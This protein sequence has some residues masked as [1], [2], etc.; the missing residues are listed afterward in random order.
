MPAYQGR[1][2][3]R[4][5]HICGGRI[6]DVPRDPGEAFITAAGSSAAALHGGRG[7]D[8]VPGSC[9][10]PE[11]V[12]GIITNQPRLLGRVPVMERSAPGSTAA[13]GA[14]KPQLA[15]IAL[16]SQSRRTR[17]RRLR[18][19]AAYSA[20][21]KPMMLRRA[22]RAL[23]RA[24]LT[25]VVAR[26]RRRACVHA[27][28]RSSRASV[29][30]RRRRGHVDRPRLHTA[31]SAAQGDFRAQVRAHAPSARERRLYGPCRLDPAIAAALGCASCS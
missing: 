2:T 11:A 3:G 22:H 14:G 12:A 8:T 17:L 13:L 16:M 19:G 20:P 9:A 29:V 7:G 1:P 21:L 5:R 30:Q 10:R 6:A 4:S 28:P 27:V 18:A 26:R 15:L 25:E 23:P 31:I 24:V